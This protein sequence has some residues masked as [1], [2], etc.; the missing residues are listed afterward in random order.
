MKRRVCN[1]FFVGAAAFLFLYS[2]SGDSFQTF[3]FEKIEGNIQKGPYLNGTSLVVYERNEDMTATGK[4]FSAQIIDNKGT[5]AL[6]D[7]V[8]SS[9]YVEMMATGFYFNEIT[10][11]NSE[12]Q[13]TL[14]A[15]AD[16]SGNTSV[17]VNALSHLER[18]RV[19]YLISEGS[20]FQEAKKQAQTE[21]LKIFEI[22]KE[23][24]EL[25][26]NLDISKEGE[27]HAILLAVSAI[28]QGYMSVSD[29]SELLANISTDLRED[30]VLDSQGLGTILISNARLIKPQKIRENLETQYR[31]LGME[32][33]LPG[34]EKYIEN[35]ISQSP[36]TPAASI[37]YPETGEHGWNILD[38]ERTEYPSG[39]YSMT[40][41]LQTGATLKVKI[42]GQ[43]NWMFPAFHGDTGWK[44]SSWNDVDFS[45][46]FTAVRT[47]KI[48]FE[49]IFELFG[50]TAN[51]EYNSKVYIEVYENDD[52][53]P[54]WTKEI[55]IVASS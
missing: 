17:N 48:D 19:S 12:S 47:G 24:M 22:E 35:F 49:I 15:L 44:E 53:Q 1:L 23:D 33:T 18:N 11:D 10:N 29:L 27:D 43:N 39:T 52:L 13:L 42:A 3:V 6:K 38:R 28:L 51:P 14:Y 20:S 54:T 46:Y 36:F 16:L 9:E 7:L 37:Q 8:L 40:A 32:I 41:I 45:R 31:T 55:Q 50:D 25:S 21:I 2:C 5:F 4:S 30:G 26:E 34:F